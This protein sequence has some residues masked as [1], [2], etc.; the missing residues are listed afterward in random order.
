MEK[1][2]LQDVSSEQPSVQTVPS[3]KLEL[4]ESSARYTL[5][6]LRE[7]NQNLQNLC[8][9]ES[10]DE[11]ERFFHANDLMESSIAYDEIKKEC[12]EIFGEQI[13]IHNH[14]LL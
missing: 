2:A 4:T 8:N 7:Q 1:K 9:D 3:V 13:L 12:V 11:D 5:L 14:E 6:A 10:I